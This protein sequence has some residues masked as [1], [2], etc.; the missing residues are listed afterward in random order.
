VRFQ[1]GFTKRASVRDVLVRNCQRQ[2][3][4]L[5]STASVSP[6]RPSRCCADQAEPMLETRCRDGN[7][8]RR[9]NGA[10]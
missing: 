9:A 1:P 8:R 10:S 2:G 6:P 5:S 3:L 4:S 7:G